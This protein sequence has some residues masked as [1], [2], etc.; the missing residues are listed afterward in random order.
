[1]LRCSAFT[2][3]Q[4]LSHAD[5]FPAG[6]R[7]PSIPTANS[8]SANQE[9]TDEGGINTKPSYPGQGHFAGRSKKTLTWQLL[10][11]A[12]GKV[13]NNARGCQNAIGNRFETKTT[14][15]GFSAIET[16]YSRVLTFGAG[17]VVLFGAGC[18][19]SLDPGTTVPAGDGVALFTICL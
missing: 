9:M 12:A 6:A 17:V 11:R 19:C 13:G 10:A 18:A 7:A 4:A 3:V 1:M 15:D 5:S 2:K 14:S 16:C 8:V